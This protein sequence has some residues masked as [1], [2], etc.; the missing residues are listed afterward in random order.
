MFELLKVVQELFIELPD[1]AFSPAAAHFSGFVN[2]YA[3]DSIQ[4][5]GV[6]YF[7]TV[8]SKARINIKMTKFSSNI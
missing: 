2:H 7:V 1:L 3:D 8:S 4:S 5:I 6:H